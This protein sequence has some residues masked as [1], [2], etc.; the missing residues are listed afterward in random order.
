MKSALS[1]LPF[2]KFDSIDALH[3]YKDV[4]GEFLEVA[5]LDVDYRYTSEDRFRAYQ[6]TL[7]ELDLKPVQVHLP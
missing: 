6:R 3:H 5:P 2:V 1:M 4:G 7:D